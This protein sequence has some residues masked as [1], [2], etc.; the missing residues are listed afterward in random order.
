MPACD[1]LIDLFS[2]DGDAWSV[3]VML[4]VLRRMDILRITAVTALI[5]SNA[6]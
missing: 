5:H 1:E 2:I 3:R 6:R 4:A